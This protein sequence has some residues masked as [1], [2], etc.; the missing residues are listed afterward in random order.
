MTE[1]RDPAAIEGWHVH[2]Y[3]DPATRPTAE[4]VRRALENAF[5]TARFG[6]FH[7]VPVGPHPI[8]M[9]QVAFAPDLFPVL[10]PWLALNRS[11][12]AVLV[13]PETGDA[14]ADHT[15]H[16]LWLGRMLELSLD[17]LR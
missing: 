12:L 9:Y 10:V 3:Y 1:P 5:P 6:R 4:A 2:V 15:D 8:A 14:V 7:D 11:G 13:H 16:A 17:A